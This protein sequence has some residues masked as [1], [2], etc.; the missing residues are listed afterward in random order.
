[1]KVTRTLSGY[2]NRSF[3]DLKAGIMASLRNYF[4]PCPKAQLEICKKQKDLSCMGDVSKCRKIFI[5]VTI[6][7]EE[8]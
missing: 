6:E 1:M 2:D 3:T 5:T 7:D 4:Y 8:G